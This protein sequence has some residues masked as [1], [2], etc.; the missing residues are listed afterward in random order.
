MRLT[1]ACLYTGVGLEEYRT[2]Q[3]FG[4]SY[5]FICDFLHSERDY[6]YRI[7][8]T[9]I[10]D[11]DVVLMYAPFVLDC[12]N[13]WITRNGDIPPR[14]TKFSQR[15]T[16]FDKVLA[17]QYP[18]AWHTSILEAT[19]CTLGNL[20]EVALGWTWRFANME[21]IGNVD[22]EKVEQVLLY[23]KSELGDADLHA[24]L[25]QLYQAFQGQQTN[26][27]TV[28]G[29]LVTRLFHRLRC[30]LLLHSVLSANSIAAGMQH[31]DSVLIAKKIVYFCGKQV[32]RRGGP[33]E[34]Y[35]LLTWHNFSYLMIGGIGLPS[36]NNSPES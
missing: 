18:G 32:I 9:P 13:A 10:D 11:T 8:G 7:S 16:Y 3:Y 26:H 25:Q 17:S 14:L 1:R 6:S 20:M 2:T 15:V 30:V 5:N 19:N 36:D 22:R 23:I 33:I 29:Q 31:P 34:D 28:E 21:A 24:A 4:L 35:L 27:T 12:V